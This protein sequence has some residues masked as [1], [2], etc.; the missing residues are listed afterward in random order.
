DRV[1]PRIVGKEDWVR[2]VRHRLN[3]LLSRLDDQP[4]LGMA[5]GRLPG[6]VLM[7]LPS[8]IVAALLTYALVQGLNAA[9]FGRLEI[10]PPPWFV[11]AYSALMGAL[12]AIGLMSL[13][14]WA[15]LNY[16]A[17]DVSL[18][19]QASRRKRRRLRGGSVA[20]T[21]AILALVATIL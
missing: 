7:G 1:Y 4:R 3:A 21:V 9:V 18:G 10:E 16:P 13:W 8:F 11:N 19:N 14:R 12:T 6:L 20:V 17:V 5:L 2:A 15:R